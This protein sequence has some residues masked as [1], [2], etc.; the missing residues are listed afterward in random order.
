MTALPAGCIQKNRKP[1]PMQAKAWALSKTASVAAA[2]QHRSTAGRVLQA[3]SLMPHAGNK[4]AA[5]AAGSSC[6]CSCPGHLPGHIRSGRT[7]GR[8]GLR[9]TGPDDTMSPAGAGLPRAMTCQSAGSVLVDEAMVRPEDRRRDARVAAAGRRGP[10]PCRGPAFP[11][12]PLPLPSLPQSP[13]QA[14]VI[15]LKEERCWCGS[16]GRAAD[17]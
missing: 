9:K 10:V 14:A 13:C 8:S 15:H 5:G 2:A 17:L 3:V 1:P 12:V 16:I 7:G 4:P 6:G 11:C